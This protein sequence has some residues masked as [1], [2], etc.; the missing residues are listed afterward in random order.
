MIYC[1][2]LKKNLLTYSAA[3]SVAT[4][5]FIAFNVNCS[6]RNVLNK[7]RIKSCL[8]FWLYHLISREPG[9]WL[10]LTKTRSND[11]AGNYM[12]KFNNRYARTRCEI[13]LKLTIKTPERR[14]WRRTHSTILPNWPNDWAVLWV[15]ICT[16]HLTVFILSRARFRVNPHFIVAW[17]SRKSLLEAGAKSHYNNVAKGANS[18]WKM[19]KNWFFFYFFVTHCQEFTCKTNKVYEFILFN[20][21]HFTRLSQVVT[22]INHGLQFFLI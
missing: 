10:K 12:F 8:L 14:H 7:F 9:F 6:S 17:M 19:K 11:P 13:C 18:P 5:N 20:C 22:G 16:V 15:L 21:S 4:K 1:F 2:L 3:I